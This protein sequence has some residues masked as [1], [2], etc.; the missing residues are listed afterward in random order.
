MVFT[1]RTGKFC[2]NVT[3]GVGGYFMISSGLP[4]VNSSCRTASGLV[5]GRKISGYGGEMIQK[6]CYLNLGRIVRASHKK[7][8]IR[9]LNFEVGRKVN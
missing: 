9:R 5:C 6:F 3:L 1:A 4:L 8:N 2:W 7:P